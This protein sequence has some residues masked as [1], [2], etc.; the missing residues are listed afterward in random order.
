MSFYFT[1]RKKWRNSV[2]STGTMLVPM[3][4]LWGFN[5]LL[6]LADTTGKPSFITRYRIQADKN[7]P[8]GFGS[9]LS[10]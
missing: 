8:V 2:T 3:V 9:L 4:V 10:D 5:A 1:K 6:L 7:D